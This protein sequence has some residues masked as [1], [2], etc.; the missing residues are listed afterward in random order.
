MVSKHPEFLSVQKAS[1]VLRLCDSDWRAL[2][3][4]MELLA[5]WLIISLKIMG[6]TSDWAQLALNIREMKT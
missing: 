6:L 1:L 4:L 2:P 3:L 5:A